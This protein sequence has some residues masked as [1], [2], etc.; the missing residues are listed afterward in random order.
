MSEGADL[1]PIGGGAAPVAPPPA[2][3][4]EPLSAAM[5]GAPGAEAGLRLEALERPPR[6]MP[7]EQARPLLGDGDV[8][9]FERHGLVAAVIGWGTRSRFSH[10]GLVLRL[11]A[12]EDHPDRVMLLESSEGHGCRMVPL[13][14]A[15]AGGGAHA[16]RPAAWVRLDRAAAIAA[17]LDRLGAPYGWRSILLDAVS[18]LPLLAA[19]GT[20]GVLRQIPLLGAALARLP[21]G[22]AYSTDDLEDAVRDVKCSTYVALAYRA[23]GVDLVRE[24]ADRS[25]DPGDLA[26]S[27]ALDHV[28]E[29]VP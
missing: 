22:K 4:L 20:L 9:L 7:Y 13:S 16:Y 3:P 12:T 21:W 1:S 19:L 29:L 24:L 23:G 28:T 11:Q 5:S 15:V 25:T 18:R 2:P 14:D 17:A 26:R 6:R 10:A 27:L 8:I